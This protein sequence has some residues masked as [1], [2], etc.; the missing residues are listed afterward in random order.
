MTFGE[1]FST[2]FGGATPFAYQRALAERDW[3]DALIAPTGL[4]KTAAVVLAWL[5]KRAT[6]PE[7]TPRRLVYCLPMRT[8]ADQTHRNATGWLGRLAPLAGQSV[9]ELP[10][11]D[12][13]VH[14]LMGGED[15]SPWYEHPE[16][17]A[18]VIGTQDMLISRALMRGYAMS[19]FRWPVDFAPA[20]QRC[21]VGL[22]RGAA[23]EFGSGDLDAARRV[24]T[25]ARDADWGGQHL[26]FGDAAPG[27]VAH[28]RRP[29]SAERLARPERLRRRQGVSGPFGVCS[30]RR[31]VS[32]R[33]RYVRPPRRK[34]ILPPTSA[35]WP[36]RS[37]PT[38]S[39][40]G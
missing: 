40:V 38:I 26:G 17:A 37:S 32:S 3:P 23:H 1:F 7:T 18:I 28:G 31:S 36:A 24:S 34:A 2:A 21:P 35:I 27:V 29:G 4:G 22:R 30:T 11:A 15:E 39:R 20:A 14:L 12:R 25:P 6:A 13:D 10:D 9:G 16:R 5:W 8:L 33:H 19:R